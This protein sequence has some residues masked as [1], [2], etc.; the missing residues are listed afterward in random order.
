MHYGAFNFGKRLVL[1]FFEYC[2]CFSYN[3]LSMLISQCLSLCL[4][5]GVWKQT[6][7]WYWGSGGN[8]EEVHLVCLLILLSTGAAVNQC[9]GIQVIQRTD[10]CTYGFC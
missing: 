9:Y 1:C 3:F 4:D 10:R 5:L 8:G 2:C 6:H 7:L